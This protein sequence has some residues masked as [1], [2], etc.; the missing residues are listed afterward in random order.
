VVFLA[1]FAA[2][3]N[4]IS[5]AYLACTTGPALFTCAKPLLLL[6]LSEELARWP[7]F[8]DFR[9]RPL[10]TQVTRIKNVDRPLKFLSPAIFARVWSFFDAAMGKEVFG[11]KGALGPVNF[12]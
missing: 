8:F 11:F 10:K 9:H 7:I 6:S 5:A 2:A 4:A 12:P 1:A 3:R